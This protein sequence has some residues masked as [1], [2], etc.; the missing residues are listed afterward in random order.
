MTCSETARS[1]GK[2]R[3]CLLVSLLWRYAV[4]AGLVRPDADAE[5]VAALTRR[6]TPGLAG[7]LVMIALG[8]FLPVVAAFGYL[9][10]ALFTLAPIA[11]F[12]RPRRGAPR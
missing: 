9:A 4:H 2:P 1:H 3:S 5:D 12:T 11:L 7:Y 8:L 10:I 6:L